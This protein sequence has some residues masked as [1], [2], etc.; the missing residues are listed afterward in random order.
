VHGLVVEKAKPRKVSIS[1]EGLQH[2]DHAKMNVRILGNVMV[3]KRKNDQKVASRVR[4]KTQQE[5]DKLVTFTKQCP[6][7]P[8]SVLVKLALEQLLQVLGFNVWGLG[9]VPRNATSRMEKDED[10]EEMIRSTL[11]K[12]MSTIPKISVGQIN[13]RTTIPNVGSQCL[14][15]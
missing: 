14:G 3:V 7:F 2:Q 8:K 11:C 1:I 15:P 9:S 6:P 12:T 10:L 4:A 13:F 5:W